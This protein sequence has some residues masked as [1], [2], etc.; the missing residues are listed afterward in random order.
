MDK[1]IYI[2]TSGALL[3]SLRLQNASNNLANIN[4]SG[5]RS[6]RIGSR[7]QEFKDTLASVTAPNDKR[8]ASTIQET[9]GVV[10]TRTYINFE[11]GSATYTGNPLN[12]A[13]MDENVFF[14]I[15]TPQGEEYTRAGNFTLNQSGQLVSADGF[16]VV[17]NNGPIE[18]T[19]TNPTIT[20]NGSVI[21]SEKELGKIR[22]VMIDNLSLLEHK[23]GTRFS[24]PPNVSG[25]AVNANPRLIE[26]TVE[27][28]NTG[29]LESI[30]DMVAIQKNFE[31][32]TKVVRTI[33]E[34]N[35]RVIRLARTM[36]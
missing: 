35:D 30:V 34:L 19:G 21:S 31:A 32:Y 18:I 1:G 28:S 11:P 25:N 12:A 6:Q 9:P 8:A 29:M 13:L 3:E 15:Q 22:T 24:F 16:P 23:G 2:S 20:S 36:G 26:Q 17:G 14:V 27:V 4:T 7:Q 33:D 5:F 10:H